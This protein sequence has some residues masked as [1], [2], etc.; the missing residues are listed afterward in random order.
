MGHGTLQLPIADAFR[1]CTTYTQVRRSPLQPMLCSARYHCR[2]SGA[3][4]CPEDR[5]WS[6]AFCFWWAQCPSPQS[7]TGYRKLLMEYSACIA[8]IF[9]ITNL[10]MLTRVDITCKFLLFL[11]RYMA[12]VLTLN[13]MS[14]RCCL[15]PQLVNRGVFFRNYLRLRPAPSSTSL[16]ASSQ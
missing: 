11:L 5:N 1:M 4:S 10:H 8:S 15:I 14:R 12:S 13:L 6:F 16:M 9:R 7:R 3:C 2:I